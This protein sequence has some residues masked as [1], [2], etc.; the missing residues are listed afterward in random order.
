MKTTSLVR[1]L[2]FV[3]SIL[4]TLMTSF[5]NTGRATQQA[6]MR[7]RLAERQRAKAAHEAADAVEDA[8]TADEQIEL[9]PDAGLA[10]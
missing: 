6:K 2:I 9:S 5:A 8:V 3:N 10:Y 1:L 7:A 4:F